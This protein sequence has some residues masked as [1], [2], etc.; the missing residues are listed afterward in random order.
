MANNR[1]DINAATV[2]DFEQLIGI[3]RN[4]AEAIVKHRKVSLLQGLWSFQLFKE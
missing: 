2:D 4:K 1:L 3:G